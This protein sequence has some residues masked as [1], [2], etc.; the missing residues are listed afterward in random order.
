[1]QS[2]TPKISDSV[3]L[4]VFNFC[5][6]EVTIGNPLT[7]EISPS[8]FPTCLDV[9][10]KIHQSTTT[11]SLE[12]RIKGRYPSPIIHFNRLNK[13]IQSYLLGSLTLVVRKATS[14]QVSG[15]DQLVV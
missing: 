8:I 5:L 2:W 12:L 13:L 7:M 6:V 3:E 4:R 9:L 10:N 11:M 14:V 1:M 15:L